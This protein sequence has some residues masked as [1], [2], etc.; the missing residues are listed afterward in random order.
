MV[1]ITL[2]HKEATEVCIHTVPADKFQELAAL[3]NAEIVK[4]DIM[5]YCKFEIG[6]VMITL[7]ED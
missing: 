7:F 2:D 1:S 3:M 5:R 4:M 6:E